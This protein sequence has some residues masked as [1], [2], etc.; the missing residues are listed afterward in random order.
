[1]KSPSPRPAFARVFLGPALF[2][3]AVVTVSACSDG[4]PDDR[5]SFTYI[6][7]AILV[8][9]CATS[10]CH[11]T[12][13]RSKSID[14]E[15]RESAFGTFLDQDVNMLAILRGQGDPVKG[16]RLRMPLDEPLPDADLDLI[17]RWIAARLPNN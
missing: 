10:G 7:T 2:V 6:H 5:V 8:P 1:M 16:T 11:S 9:N 15:D 17:A 3:A 12:L 14:M 13:S 4:Y